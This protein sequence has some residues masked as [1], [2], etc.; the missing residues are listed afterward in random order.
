MSKSR[1]L[2]SESEKWK[3][4]KVESG[5]WKVEGGKK[6]TRK[7][8]KIVQINADFLELNRKKHKCNII[9]FKSRKLIP[10]HEQNINYLY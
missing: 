5:K 7:F 2:K 1:K 10:I 9:F 4:E 6:N 8:S 3:S